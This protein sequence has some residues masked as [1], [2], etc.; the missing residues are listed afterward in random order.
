[1]PVGTAQAGV[2]FLPRCRPAGTETSSSCEQHNVL[3]YLCALS[4]PHSRLLC[5]GAVPLVPAPFAGVK[6]LPS[7]VSVEGR[8]AT[9]GVMH[10]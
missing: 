6:I 4:L 10:S 9:Y 2:R 3:Q 1:M 7:R 5:A 8:D